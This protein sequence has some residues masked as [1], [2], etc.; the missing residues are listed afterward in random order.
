MFGLSQKIYEQ[1]LNITKKY[2]YKFILFGSRARG[3]YKLNSDID[4][5]VEG[6]VDKKTEYKIKNEL[7]LLD[8]P[9]TI[10][11]VFINK[12]IKNELEQSIRE[13]G[14]EL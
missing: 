6:K 4:I 7:D 2:N 8:I 12:G 10:D 3:D 14:V 9:Y 13:E 1:I 11:I 5:A